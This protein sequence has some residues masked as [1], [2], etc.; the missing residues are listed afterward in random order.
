[1]SQGGVGVLKL[2]PTGVSIILRISDRA[3]L[4]AQQIYITLNGAPVDP[5]TVSWTYNLTNVSPLCFQVDTTGWPNCNPGCGSVTNV[6]G[7]SFSGT[8]VATVPSGATAT[9]GVTC[10]YM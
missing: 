5:S 1:M 4:G 9:L 10:Q 2:S 7:S 3:T 6:G 8:A